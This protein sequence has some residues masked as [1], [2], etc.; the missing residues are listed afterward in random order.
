MTRSRVW[1]FGVLVAL[2]LGF[3][4][5]STVHAQQFDARV[6]RQLD[7]LKEEPS[8]QEAQRAALKFFSIDT[9]TVDSMRSRASTKALLPRLGARYRRTT[10]TLDLDRFDFTQLLDR[11]AGRDD[12][13]TIGNEFEVSAAWD[14]SRIVFNSEV[15]DV[16][17]LVVLQE[18]VLKEVTR[19]FYTRRRL[20]VDLIL[21]PPSNPETKLSKELR[22]E[23]LTSTLD[24]ITGNLFSKRAGKGQAIP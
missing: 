12:G 9:D 8:I 22:I 7:E 17:S 19:L 15:L 11:V 1:I 2:F 5:A 3:G 23:E 18:S 20:Q 21:S 13:Q 16:S 24:A 10:S 14:L 4:P 6:Q